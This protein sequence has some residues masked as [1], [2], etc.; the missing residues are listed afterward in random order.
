MWAG[1]PTLGQVQQGTKA[2]VEGASKSTVGTLTKT[3]NGK[4]H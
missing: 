4:A 1:N 3:V 2:K